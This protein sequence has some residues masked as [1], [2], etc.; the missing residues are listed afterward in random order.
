VSASL[1]AAAPASADV[2]D[3]SLQADFPATPE[4]ELAPDAA[5][6]DIAGVP[7]ESDESRA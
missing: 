7:A 6:S 5:A 2:V 3:V 1:D 4:P